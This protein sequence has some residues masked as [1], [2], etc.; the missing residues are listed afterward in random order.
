VR[1]VGR[2]RALNRAR[3]LLVRWEELARTSRAYVQI[4]CALLCFQHCD[5]SR[6]AFL[7]SEQGRSALSEL[8]STRTPIPSRLDILVAAP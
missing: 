3:R 5:H 6:A 7:V 2:W 8:G 4:A 1:S